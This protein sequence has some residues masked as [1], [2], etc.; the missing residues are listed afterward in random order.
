MGE[1]DLRGDIASALGDNGG[2]STEVVV[3]TPE[4][5]GDGESPKIPAAS[6]HRAAT[7][8]ESPALEG[9]GKV[10]DSLGRFVPKAK[11]AQEGPQGAPGTNGATPPVL[12]PP[13]A[14]TA[15]PAAS[16]PVQTPQS[17]SPAV[18]DEHWAKLPAAV[19]QEVLRREQEVIQA[20]RQ[21]APARQLGEQFHNAVQPYMATI[22]AEG[23]DP[24][25]AV[26]NLMQFATRMRMGTQNEKAQTAAWI[27]KTY[28]VD[29]QAL[30]SALAGVVPQGQQADPQQAVNQAV[31]QALLPIYNA[32]QQRR[33]LVDRQATAV[34]RTE[35]EAFAANPKNRFFNDLKAD[36]ADMVDMAANQGRDLSLQE[37]YD[38]AGM[39]HPEISKIMI[40]ERQGA[41][42][43]QLTAA[44]QKAR[45]SAVSVRGSAPVGNPGG[46]EPSSIRESIEAAIAAH[47]RY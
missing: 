13:A 42:A 6:E 7:P 33:E 1:D 36:M 20:F 3:E 5:S 28:G 16:P 12:T 31:Q 9:D 43:Q 41:N 22:Q 19:Q 14:A 27:V 45:A 34:A 26:T 18:R 17:W 46:P 25:T 21:G 47:E 30:D 2:D 32:A 10:R 39:L 37:A 11:E 29:I 8:A 24:L 35:M 4:R 15:V 44:A 38:R 23:V 40:A